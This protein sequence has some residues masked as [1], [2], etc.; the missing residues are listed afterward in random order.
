MRYQIYRSGDSASC[1]PPGEHC[2]KTLAVRTYGQIAEALAQRGTPGLTPTRVAHICR[3]AE[4]KI[5]RAL[6]A[7][8][9]V[10]QRL[11]PSAARHYLSGAN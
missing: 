9:E 6:L 1:Q 3:V 2:L 7:D 10:H 8:P 4:I 5:A 11:R